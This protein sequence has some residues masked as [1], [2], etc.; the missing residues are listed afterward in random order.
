MVKQFSL[1]A[2]VSNA[3]SNLGV[4]NVCP[5][6]NSNDNTFMAVETSANLYLE[7]MVKYDSSQDERVS[8]GAVEMPLLSGVSVTILSQCKKCSRSC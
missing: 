1:S 3:D 7:E 2:E 5:D 6:L 8:F 4:L